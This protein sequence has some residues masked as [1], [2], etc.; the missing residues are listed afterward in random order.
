MDSY[1]VYIKIKEAAEALE[2]YQKANPSQSVWDSLIE[3]K[4]KIITEKRHML[5]S[6]G[7]VCMKCGGSGR[8]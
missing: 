1:T 5:A 2:E 3:E 6:S 7:Q 8:M 4:A